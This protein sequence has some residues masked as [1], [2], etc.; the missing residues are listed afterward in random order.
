[1]LQMRVFEPNQLWYVKRKVKSPVFYYLGKSFKDLERFRLKKT[2]LSVLRSL[3]GLIAGQ[4]T[5]LIGQGGYKP[6]MGSST[7]PRLHQKH[8][9]AIKRL[10]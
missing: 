4:A 1:M 8:G 2:F 3:P 5:G 6:G 9:C 7:L 10:V